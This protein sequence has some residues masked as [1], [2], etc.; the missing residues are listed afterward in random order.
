MSTEMREVTLAGE[1]ILEA[2]VLVVS[3]E[4]VDPDII[5]GVIRGQ[6]RHI[7]TVVVDSGEEAM[8]FLANCAVPPKV[9]LL[10]FHLPDI[11]ALDLLRW[12]RSEA[13]TA[14]I[15]VVVLTGGINSAERREAYLLG[16]NGFIT[17]TDDV[18]QLANRLSIIKNLASC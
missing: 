10:D 16:V 6:M 9:I 2:D 14:S 3:C 15:P 18:V 11:N 4:T 17:T 5:L 12:I 1:R 8:E 7:R 13:R